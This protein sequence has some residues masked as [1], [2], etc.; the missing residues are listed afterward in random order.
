MTVAPAKDLGERL[1]RERVR[2]FVGREAEL[3][4][5]ADQLA[6]DGPGTRPA[7]FWV[8]GPGGSGKSSL[9]S[10]YARQARAARRRVATIADGSDPAAIRGA[11]VDGLGF[12]E[13]GLT[14]ADRPVV[15]LDGVERWAA[16]ED[17]LREDLLPAL[18]ARSLIVVAHRRPPKHQWLA[19]PGWRQLLRVLPLR[20]LDADAVRTLLV[21]DGLPPRL[22]PAVM[23]LTRGHPLAV[24]LCVEV[25]RRSG[26]D[27][28]PALDEEPGLVDALLSAVVE[29]PP[30]EGHR[31]AL[32]TSAHAAVTTEAILRAAM[33]EA[34]AEAVSQRWDWLRDLP[35]V[36]ETP[37]GLRLQPLAR[38]VVDADLRRRDPD[39]YALLHLRLR[40]HLLDQ[41]R[42]SAGH[43]AA[44]EQ[45]A[46]DLLFLARPLLGDGASGPAAEAR[47][48]GPTPVRPGEVGQVIDFLHRQGGDAAAGPAAWWLDRYPASFRVVRDEAGDLAGVGARLPLHL[49]P[50][51]D[52]AADPEAVRLTTHVQRQ[53]P[54]RPGE[55]ML[56]W[57]FVTDDGRGDAGRRRCAEALFRTWHLTDILLRSTTAWEFVSVEAGSD[58]WLTLLRNW[59]FAGILDDRQE[60]GQITLAHDWRRIGVGLWLERTAARELGERIDDELVNRAPTLRYA[61]FAGSVKQAL[62]DLHRPSALLRNPLLGS[63]IAQA[64]RRRT[65][66]DVSPDRVL[67][68]LICEAAQVLKADPQSQHL[69]RV[70]DRTFLRPPSSQEKAAELLDLPFTTYRRYRDRAVAAVVDW[71][72]ELEID[73]GVR[74]A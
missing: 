18:P 57:R 38:S 1:Q 25:M 69:Y 9:L 22:L 48:D 64:R 44:A 10:A 23:R 70:L 74:C 11:L 17:W 47:L 14:P 4:A 15:L 39:G 29:R 66:P 60:S 24:A 68:D 42:R 59:D 19:D 20:D 6:G 35:V 51:A 32:Q 54:A 65:D 56:A 28:V 21:A 46:G 2:N 30:G 49:V 62:R 16:G 31:M 34:S 58:S 43:P 72:W 40:E 37:T 12:A 63:G 8:H 61:D 45:A 53:A 33:P 41:L 55:Q 13:S 50:S 52:L 7:V 3:T 73:S 71:L 5:F 26:A 27:Q 67:R 36:A